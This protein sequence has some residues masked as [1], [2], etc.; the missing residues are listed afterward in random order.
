MP[1]APPLLRSTQA[2]PL[3]VGQSFEGTLTVLQ[4]LQAHYSALAG[5][6][7]VHEILALS[8]ARWS[9]PGASLS[10]G[11]QLELLSEEWLRVQALAHFAGAGGEPHAEHGGGGP[12]V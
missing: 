7:S 8:R 1:L 11:E 5:G 10:M 12:S 3:I 9:G 2:A 6:R 4:H